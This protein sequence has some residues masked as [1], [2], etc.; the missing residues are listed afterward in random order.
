MCGMLIQG[1]QVKPVLSSGHSD[2]SVVLRQLYRIQKVKHFLLTI[3]LSRTPHIVKVK[4]K[5][6]NLFLY[7]VKLSQQTKKS[8]LGVRF[9]RLSLVV[10]PIPP[11]RNARCGARACERADKRVSHNA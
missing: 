1:R 11:L 3:G 6:F 10:T 5:C 8:K 9:P 7:L 2:P 4:R